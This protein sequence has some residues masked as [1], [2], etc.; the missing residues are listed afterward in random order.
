[1]GPRGGA[2]GCATALQARRSRVSLQF[3]IDIT[4]PAAI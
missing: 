1:M 3:F 2:V 4:L